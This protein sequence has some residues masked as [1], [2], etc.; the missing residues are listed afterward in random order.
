MLGIGFMLGTVDEMK[1]QAVRA[2]AHDDPFSRQSNAGI[3]GVGEVGHEDA[4]PECCSL[5]AFHIVYIQHH[6]R[7]AL[8]KDA[9]LNLKRDLRTLQTVFQMTESGLGTGSNPQP[10]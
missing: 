8:V 7:E 4:F 1:M 9:W 10:V 6:F 2:L 5:G 3:G